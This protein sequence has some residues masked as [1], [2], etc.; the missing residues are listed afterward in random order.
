MFEN[1]SKPQ[2]PSRVPDFL[3]CD[4]CGIPISDYWILQNELRYCSPE[5]YS[6]RVGDSAICV[7]TGSL[8]F[9]GYCVGFLLSFTN[10]LIGIF[11]SAIFTI[12]MAYFFKAGTQHTS[13]IRQKV[14]KDSRTHKVI[15]VER[16]T[17]IAKCPSCDGNF[18]L[19]TLDTDRVIACD[20][21]GA[22]FVLKF[23]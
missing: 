19:T 3:R 8:T 16:I 5:C 12:S 20:Y 14:P 17:S 21:C 4:W 22:M 11:V 6:A 2:K 13:S 23:V 1:P 7:I 18:D 15:L 10:L 9:L